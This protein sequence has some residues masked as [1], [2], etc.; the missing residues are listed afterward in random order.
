MCKTTLGYHLP[1]FN[2]PGSACPAPPTSRFIRPGSAGPPALGS[3]FIRPGSTGPP[4]L[5][6]RFIYPGSIGGGGGG[7]GGDGDGE[8]EEE[9]EDLG[10]RIPTRIIRK[11]HMPIKIQRTTKSEKIRAIASFGLIPCLDMLSVG[12]LSGGGV[13]V[14]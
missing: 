3:R 5:G 11:R 9:G 7:G 13:D 12:V 2:L 10:L 6:S 14:S 8:R 4:P 1:R